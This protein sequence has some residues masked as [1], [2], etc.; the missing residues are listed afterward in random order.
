MKIC[1]LSV[2]WVV[3]LALLTNDK[4]KDSQLSPTRA[5]PLAELE[6]R[7]RKD[8]TLNFT[9]IDMFRDPRFTA[10]AY[11][12]TGFYLSAAVALSMSNLMDFAVPASN[13]SKRRVF[14]GD[15]RDWDTWQLIWYSNGYCAT[16][17][18]IRLISR[19]YTGLL[20]HHSCIPD[21]HIPYRDGFDGLE[22]RNRTRCAGPTLE[23]ARL[24]RSRWSRH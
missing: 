8:M 7:E 9:G 14:D 10:F 16:S 11:R 1:S 4:D 17:T 20:H 22:L 13:T 5:P 21:L 18:S 19:G 23:K 6:G 3:A 2:H 15:G 12:Q 24:S